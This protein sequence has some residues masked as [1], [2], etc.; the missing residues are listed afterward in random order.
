M[1]TAGLVEA[2]VARN[3]AE[4]VAAVVGTVSAVGGVAVPATSEVAGFV[5][6]V[7]PG[8]CAGAV[9]RGNKLHIVT[10]PERYFDTHK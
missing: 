6:V 8:L 7:A 4:A 3:V 1:S 10:M 2:S 5:A 9:F